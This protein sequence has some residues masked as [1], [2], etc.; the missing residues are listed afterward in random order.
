MFGRVDLWLCE[1]IVVVRL[2]ILHNLEELNLRNLDCSSVPRDVATGLSTSRKPCRCTE[3]EAFFV[4]AH[5]GWL[6]VCLYLA[7]SGLLVSGV[8]VIVVEDDMRGRH[9]C[10]FVFMLVLSLHVCCWSCWVFFADPCHLVL[11][12]FKASKHTS[13]PMKSL[14]CV[15][16]S[17]LSLLMYSLSSSSYFHYAQ[18]NRERSPSTH[19]TH[20]WCE[21]FTRH[22]RPHTSTCA[23][24]AL[25]TCSSVVSHTSQALSTYWK[26]KGSF[27]SHFQFRVTFSMKTCHD[28]NPGNM[29]ICS[30]TSESPVRGTPET[31]AGNCFLDTHSERAT[32]AQPRHRG[33]EP[34]PHSVGTAQIAEHRSS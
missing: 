23:V 15:C 20:T 28:L 26:A 34:P 14:F 4:F 13:P 18:E 10:L 22:Q 16:S 27:G 8:T 3:S 11:R 31:P 30:C 24:P 29:R 21:P 32:C 25:S 17:L 6:D 7:T 2:S 1:Y 33:A 5:P 9:R 19:G 12:S